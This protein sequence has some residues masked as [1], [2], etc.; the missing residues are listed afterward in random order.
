MQEAQYYETNPTAKRVSCRLCPQ[1][2]NI[3]S[4]QAG[5]CKVRI[6]REGILETINYA[7]ISSMALD[8]IEKKPLYHYYPGR[9]VLSVGTIG[10]NL[11]CEF[12]QNWEISQQESSTR[13]L[14]PSELTKLAKDA[15]ME[16]RSIGLAY[17]YSEPGVWF[18]FLIDIMPRVREQG[19]KNILVTNGFLNPKPWQELLEWTDA[20]NIDLKG[21]TPDYYQRL[22]HG[23]LEPVKE[24]IITAA[25][26]IHL[27]L[28]TLIIPG[29]ND[30]PEQIKALAQWIADINP[31]IPLHLSRYFPNYKLTQPA[32]PISIMKQSYEVAKEYLQFVYLGNVGATNHTY[33]PNCGAIIIAREDFRTKVLAERACSICD[34]KINFI[35]ED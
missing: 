7:R 20:A 19:L 13:L 31:Q 2:C 30:Q 25:D 9:T 8:P 33:C 10:C 23:K 26:T 5:F 27:E 32:T 34:R 35:V 15:S 1:E 29:Q 11:G 12:C 3:S 28:T 6:N 22:C 16:Q 4:G 24:N 17:T 18:E 14:T 21:F